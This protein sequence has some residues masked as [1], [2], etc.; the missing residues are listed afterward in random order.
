[1]ASTHTDRAETPQ[2]LPPRATLLQPRE[3]EEKLG[4]RERERESVFS[5]RAQQCNTLL[6]TK[7]TPKGSNLPALVDSSHLFDTGHESERALNEDDSG[8][9]GE[10]SRGRVV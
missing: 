3:L 6:A 8:P 7:T 1:V 2:L 9:W 10:E 4:R 5:A